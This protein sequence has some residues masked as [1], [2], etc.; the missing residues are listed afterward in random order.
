[1]KIDKKVKVHIIFLFSNYKTIKVSGNF[2]LVCNVGDVK[3][4]KVAK[5]RNQYDQLPHLTQ[6]TTWESGKNH[7]RLESFYGNPSSDQ[8]LQCLHT[9][10]FNYI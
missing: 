8:G 1:M 6:D 3:I 9:E 10:C 7:I 2:M 4:R 5:I